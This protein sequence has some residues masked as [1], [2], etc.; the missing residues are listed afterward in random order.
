MSEELA[1]T[2]LTIYVTCSALFSFSFYRTNNFFSKKAKWIHLVLIWILPFL[3]ILFLR[4][5]EKPIPG[6]FDH[7]IK[8][9]E[10]PYLDENSFHES[11]QAF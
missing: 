1:Y 7:S 9:K 2:L 3:W 11:G 10:N 5:M 6:S 4:M 8:R